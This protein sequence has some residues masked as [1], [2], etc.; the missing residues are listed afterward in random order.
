MDPSHRDRIAFVRVCSGH[1]E[2]GM[3]VTH[4]RTGKP[5]ATKYAHSVFGQDRETRRRGLPRRRGRPRQRQRRPRRRLALPRR[6]GRR[7][8]RI[9]SFAPEHFSVARVRDT[10]RFKQFRKG[11][12]QLDEEGVVQV[13]R[14]PDIG[15]QAPVLAAVGPMQFEVAVHRLENEFGAPVELSPTVV[16]GRP[17]HRRGQRR[18]AAADARRRRARPV[19]RHPA[20]RCSRAPTGSTGSWPT[21]PSWCSNPWSPANSPP[22]DPLAGSAG[23][24]AGSGYWGGGG[25]AW[26]GRWGRGDRG[27]GCT[28]DGGVG[29]GPVRLDV[30]R[31]WHPPGSGPRRGW[32]SGRGHQRPS[33]LDWTGSPETGAITA[34][35]RRPRQRVEADDDRD[36]VHRDERVV[37]GAVGADVA[38]DLEESGAVARRAFRQPRADPRS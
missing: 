1:F 34:C 19:R 2:R 35:E 32:R 24:G 33:S 7:S 13:L 26:L 14:D 12:A 5:F 28:G 22:T 21:S 37:A 15:D 6:A 31:R 29:F 30:S 9:P 18:A 36:G 25:G 10:G 38:V 8:R 11:I 4:G 27:G 17:P 3:V 20:R 23:E 16:H